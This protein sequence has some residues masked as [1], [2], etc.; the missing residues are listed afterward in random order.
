MR[1]RTVK[2]SRGFAYVSFY[3]LKDAES[4]R[5]QANHEKILKQ[6]L[7]V[8]WKKNLKEVNREA[9]VIVKNLDESVTGQTLD[10]EFSQFGSIFSS[11]VCY[12]T[13][14]NSRG[15]GYV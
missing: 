11:I 4:A 5:L 7:R 2:T 15:Y 9:N 6:E 8:T 12:D 10:Q 14:G 3:Q 13:N 1:D